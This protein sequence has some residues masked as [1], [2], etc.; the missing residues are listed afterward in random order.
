MGGTVLGPAIGFGLDDAPH[1]EPFRGVVH[2]V[3]ADTVPG[4]PEHGSSVEIER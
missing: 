2:E 1:D 4:Y 3:L